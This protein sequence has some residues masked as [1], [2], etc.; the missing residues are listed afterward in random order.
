[1]LAGA[2]HQTA[3][4]SLDPTAAAAAGLGSTSLVAQVEQTVLQVNE[5]TGHWR[6]IRRVVP[7]LKAFPNGGGGGG[8]KTEPGAVSS[9]RLS[10]EEEGRVWQAMMSGVAGH[11]L[12]SQLTAENEAVV[13]AG[14]EAGVAQPNQE[15]E[16]WL[17][18]QQG[19]AQQNQEKQAWL[20]MHQGAAQQ[21]SEA[22]IWNGLHA[23][24]AKHN[25][26]KE[27]WLAMQQGAAQQN[28]EK[29]AWLSMHK[30]AV[31]ATAPAAGSPLFVSP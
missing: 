18:M 21:N 15:K 10:H 28:Q 14:L 27:Q 20:A 26:E 16:Q 5:E 30:G 6:K 4:A 1:M 22:A 19:A 24:G 2:Q 29:Q 7:L 25:Q 12:C 9:P 31:V 13:W 11:Q 23:G 3:A 8:G 17:A